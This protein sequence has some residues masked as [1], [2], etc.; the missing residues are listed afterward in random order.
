VI[1]VDQMICPECGGVADS[2]SVDIG[3]GLQVRGN[4]ACVCGWEIDA[5]GKANVETYDDWFVE[6]DL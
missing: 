2:D 6:D 5:D 3:V 1:G 4:F